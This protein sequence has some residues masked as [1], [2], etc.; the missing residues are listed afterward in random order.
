MESTHSLTP[1]LGVIPAKAGIYLPATLPNDRK[2]EKDVDPRLR[3]DDIEKGQRVSPE[4]TT[5]WRPV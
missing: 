2:K 4:K 3:G 1:G 5:D